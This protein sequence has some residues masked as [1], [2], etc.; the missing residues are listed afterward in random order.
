MEAVKNGHELICCAHLAPP[1][2]ILESNSFMFQSA[3]SS[4]LPTLVEECLGVPLVIRNASGNRTAINTA[5]TYT[6]ALD[7]DEV[8][9]LFDLLA[10][11]K[12]NFRDVTAISC[13][14]LFSNYQRVRVEHVCSRL[15]MTPLSFLWRMHQHILLDAMIEDGLHAVLVKVAAPGLL[16]RRHLNKDLSVLRQ[17]FKALHERF[18]FHVCGEG[19]EYESL[20]L[21]CPLFKKRL[22]LDETEIVF[23]DGDESN[24]IDEVGLLNILKCHAEE[25]DIGSVPLNSFDRPFLSDRLNHSSYSSE[26]SY[27]TIEEDDMLSSQTLPKKVISLPDGKFCAGGLLHLS[28]IVSPTVVTSFES[29]GNAAVFEALQVFDI[30]AAALKLACMSPQDVIFAHLY[31]SKIAHFALINKHYKD[32]FGSV[33]PPSRSCV[34]VGEGSLPAGRR[35]LLDICA[36]QGSGNSLRHGEQDGFHNKLREVLHVQG[37]SYWAP[38]CVGPYSQANV[39]MVFLIL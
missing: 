34:A 13:G 27:K 11:V 37:I 24:S 19:G 38:V 2:D 23:P 15:S 36:Q 10:D 30:A 29:E 4:A 9:D 20:V 6:S 17:H 32:F 39:S 3:A 21:D 35:V 1:A 7:G 26:E 31:L 12:E 18:Q 5:S 22:V 25:K 16:P 33:L 14:A 8:E 28:S